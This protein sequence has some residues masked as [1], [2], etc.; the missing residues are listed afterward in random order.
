[1]GGGG[2]GGMGVGGGDNIISVSAQAAQRVEGYVGHNA[3]NRGL[4]TFSSTVCCI[5][6]KKRERRYNSDFTGCH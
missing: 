3:Y 1:M 4:Q 2:G 6:Y 5:D